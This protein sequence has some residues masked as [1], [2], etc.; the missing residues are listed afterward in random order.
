MKQI[1]IEA[2]SIEEAV[3]EALIKLGAR[4]EEVDI[5]VIEEGSRGFLGIIG[6]RLARVR[7]KIKETPRDVI[8]TTVQEIIYAMGI[9]VAFN[10]SQSGLYWNVNFEGPDV[11]L[12]IG[13]RG[14]TINALQFIVNMIVNKRLNEKVHLIMDAEGYRRRREETLRRLARR[15]SERVKRTKRDVVL[16]PMTPQERRIIHMELKENPWV[17]TVSEGE[18]PYR[19]VVISLKR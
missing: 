9:D 14:E 19:K 11:R 4:R 18:E 12:L 8:E 13:R 7:V 3:K 1:E 15:L 16:E 17:Y 2:G 10:I 6:N 5:E